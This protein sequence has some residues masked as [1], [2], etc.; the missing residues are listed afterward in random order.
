MDRF[1]LDGKVYTAEDEINPIGCD[2][3]AGEDDIELCDNL[4]PCAAC[5]RTDNRWIIWVEESDGQV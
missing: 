5:T 4:P 3:C 2:G 1:E